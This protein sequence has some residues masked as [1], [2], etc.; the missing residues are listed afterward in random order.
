MRIIFFLIVSCLLVSCIEEIDLRIQ[1]KE[2]VLV[3]DGQITNQAPPYR[4]RLTFTGGYSSGGTIPS[5]NAVKEA[6]VY[7]ENSQQERAY[8][9]PLENENGLFE[10]YDLAYKGELGESYTLHVELE[11]GRHYLST[12][13]KITAVPEIDSIYAQKVDAFEEADYFQIYC[14]TKDIS[15]QKNY[16]LWTAF[17][18]ARVG[19]VNPQNST[20][21]LD[22]G[23]PSACWVL[24][25]SRDI[26]ILS[27]EFIDGNTIAKQAVFQSP[28]LARGNHLIE[29]S[30]YSIS[31][32]AFKY[33]T[34]FKEQ[35][36]RQGTIFDPL[37][38][39]ILGNVYLQDS[40]EERVLGYF[41]AS[42]VSRK[43][44]TIPG[45]FD[46]NEVNLNALYISQS[47]GCA[48]PFADC[49]PPKGWE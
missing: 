32:Q 4:V 34:L 6:V 2:P 39:A 12:P 10:T 3:V 29:V 11:D 31:E 46:V 49:E 36:N 48:L 37:P 9:A 17:G 8:L 27:D 1:E 33:W 14:D 26:H 25:Y 18:Y 16:Y 7:I 41:S 19:S 21:I 13:E 5:Y 20:E 28:I 45:V 23:C 38:A 43:R 35:N 47:G 30:Q 22:A 44:V 42:A 15:G 24:R 40:P